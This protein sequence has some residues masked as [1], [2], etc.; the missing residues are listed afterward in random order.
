MLTATAKGIKQSVT[1]GKLKLADVEG[2]A[3]VIHEGGDNYT[4]QPARQ[5]WRRCSHRVRSD[6]EELTGNARSS[7]AYRPLSGQ[8]VSVLRSRSRANQIEA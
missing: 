4:H 2:R 7:A 6:P 5:R 3:L 8:A 1:A